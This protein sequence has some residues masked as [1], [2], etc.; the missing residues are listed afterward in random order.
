MPAP[1]KRPIPNTPPPAPMNPTAQIRIR[2]LS[3]R[4][5]QALAEGLQWEE[6]CYLRDEQ[7]TDLQAQLAVLHPADA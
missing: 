3:R 2:A 5:N 7:I 1:N 4:L 6:Q